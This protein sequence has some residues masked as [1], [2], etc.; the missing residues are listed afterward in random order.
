ML[1]IAVARTRTR[2]RSR[3]GQSCREVRKRYLS[4]AARNFAMSSA[5]ASVTATERQPVL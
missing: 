1:G 3:S 4:K 2:A 5:L